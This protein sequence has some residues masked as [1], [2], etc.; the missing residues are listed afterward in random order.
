MSTQIIPDSSTAS[1]AND[2]SAGGTQQGSQK[3][4][5]STPGSNKSLDE[6]SHCCLKLEYRDKDLN[7]VHICKSFLNTGATV[8]IFT[9]SSNES[10]RAAGLL[11]LVLATPVFTLDGD[12]QPPHYTLDPIKQ[13]DCHVIVTTDAAAAAVARTESIPKVN[14]VIHFTFNWEVTAEVYKKRICHLKEMGRSLRFL[15]PYDDKDSFWLYASLKPPKLLGIL[16]E[17]NS[18]EIWRPLVEE[19]Q[20]IL[21][22]VP[23]LDY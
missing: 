6:I 7:L 12:F 21:P 19:A 10:R 3:V 8:M 20:A 1:T 2:I 17:E 16:V 18:L 22:K 23:R 13:G 5:S 11:K 14:V 15:T 9:R 4:K